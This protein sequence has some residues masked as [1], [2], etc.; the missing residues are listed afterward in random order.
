MDSLNK[1][2]KTAKKRMDRAWK[3]HGKGLK[4]DST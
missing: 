3:E 1:H 4:S 2:G